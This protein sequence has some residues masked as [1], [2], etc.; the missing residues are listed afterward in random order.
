MNFEELFASVPDTLVIL[1]PEPDYTI[2]AATDAYL[3]VTMRERDDIVGLRFILDAFPEK[4]IPYEENPVKKSLDRALQTKKVDYLAL[5]RYDLKRPD[6][7]FEERYWEASHTPVLDAQGQVK[8]LIQKTDDVTE[9]ELAKRAQE[10]SEDKFRFMTDMVAQLIHTADGA[11]QVNFVNQRWLNYTGLAFEELLGN[12]WKKVIH[13]DDLEGM[14]RQVNV[15]LQNNGEYQVEARVK[16]KD[17]RYRWHL[18]KSQPMLD[19]KQ[20]LV[21]RIGSTADIHDTKLMVAELLASNEQ[22]AALSDQVAAAYQKAEAER[23]TLERIV[24]QTPAVFAIMKGPEHRF[25]LVNPHFQRL[26]PNREFIGRTLAET[27]PEVGEQGYIAILDNVYAT[28]KAFVA[29]EI[30]VWMDWEATGKEEERFFTTTYQPLLEEGKITGIIVFGYE[31]T[32]RVLL[33]RQLNQRD[34]QNA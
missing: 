10:A 17:G 20:K 23:L 3:R 15:A 28:G 2:L 30:S 19:E 18:I 8:Y 25:T 27:V 33:R 14:M 31:V 12:A 22:M 7:S 32:E 34:T 6:G 1:A 21:M 13:P 29:D 11:G 16:G 5:L 26:W 24:M 4:D 9:R